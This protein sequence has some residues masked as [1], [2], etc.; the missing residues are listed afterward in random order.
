MPTDEFDNGFVLYA[1][2]MFGGKTAQ[3]IIDGQRAIIANKKAIAFKTSWDNRY[4][5]DYITANNNQLKFKAKSVPDLET[6]ISSV[7]QEN[8]QIIIIDE[9]HF[10]DENIY[11]FI[12][13]YK[14]KTR[15]IAT[16][17]QF[18]YRGNPFPLRTEKGKEYDSNKIDMGK[19]MGI[20]TK[21]KQFWPIC[22]TNE[23]I[24]CGPAYY[25]QRFDENGCLSKYSDPTIVIG[26]H[27]KYKALCDKH[28]IKPLP[29][30]TFLTP[31]G[32]IIT[33][34]QTKEYSKFLEK[35]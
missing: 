27:N 28:F 11:D 22:M 12:N 9:I 15:I 2:A 1:G 26:N 29:N 20:S 25:N 34:E 30:D 17:L 8:P 31:E 32:K 24:P 4:S 13:E 33:Y 7:K 18:D 6:L 23:I 5:E 19:L 16:G 21:I 14:H 35:K 10:F 3:A